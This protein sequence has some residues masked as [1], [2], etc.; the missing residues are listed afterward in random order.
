MSE[1]KYATEV[2]SAVAFVLEVGDSVAH[3]DEDN[4]R[5][6]RDELNKFLGADEQ[7]GLESK[8]KLGDVINIDAEEPDLPVGS[9][10]QDDSSYADIAE[11]T[12]DG[13]VWVTFLGSDERGSRRG[14]K[15]STW[16]DM[17]WTVIKVGG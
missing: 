8:W 3:L 16:N 9:R 1:L 10:I 7:P 4:A 2:F 11:K 12:E 6:L 14:L 17:N 15:W 13:W 5:L